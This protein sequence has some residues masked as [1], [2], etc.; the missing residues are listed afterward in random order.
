MAISNIVKGIKHNFKAFKGK[1]FKDKLYPIENEFQNANQ[2]EAAFIES[3]QKPLN[4]TGW[5]FMEGINSPFT[6]YDH[7]GNPFPER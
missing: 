2:A 5:S 3:R 7:S 6:L 1:K 4:V